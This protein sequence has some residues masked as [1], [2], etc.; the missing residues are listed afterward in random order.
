SDV[1]RS[2]AQ[3]TPLLPNDV[4]DRVQRLRINASRRFTNKARGEHLAGRGGTSIEFSDYRDYAAGDDMRF[5]DWNVFAR[6]HRPYLKLYRQEEEMHV[7][8]LVDAS[9]SMLFEEKL[10]CAKGL[11]AAFGVMGLWGTER[12]S[13][14]AVGGEEAG[15]SALAPCVG[16]GNMMKLF[17][18]VEGID[19]GGDAPVEGAI[20]TLL[21]FHSGRGVAVLL[22]DFLTFGDL[23]RAFNLL[24]SAG[25]EVYAIQILAPGEIDPDVTGDLRLVDAESELTLDVSSAADLVRLYQEYRDSYERNL[26]A[27]SRQRGGRFVS[28][29]SAE[30]LRS[31]LFDLLRRRGWVR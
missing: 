23:R 24:F 2:G 25:L 7:V 18:F 11:A 29:S 5:V 6:L 13:V 20:E 19:G 1:G 28:V 17:S 10:D 30:P 12:V 4:L 15:P 26:S 22:S 3:V 21:K 27:L 14:W 16:R 9:A 31:V 8:V